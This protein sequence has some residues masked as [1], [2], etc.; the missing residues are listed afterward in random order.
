MF[1]L[2]YLTCQMGGASCQDSTASKADQF[3]VL[4]L[5]LG[6][7]VGTRDGI[8]NHLGTMSRGGLSSACIT[9]GVHIFNE[10]T[11][12]M[13][14]LDFECVHWLHNFSPTNTVIHLYISYQSKQNFHQAFLSLWNN[15][16]IDRVTL[17]YSRPGSPA[18][19]LNY[20]PLVLVI[21]H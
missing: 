1:L 6:S 9:C 7:H 15:C 17:C 20:S 18:L 11:F 4:L 8:N 21:N 13:F 14:N 5:R 12:H 16:S 10:T 3:Q 19:F 2:I